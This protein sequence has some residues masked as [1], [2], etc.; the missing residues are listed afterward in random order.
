MMFEYA[1]VDGLIEDGCSN[2]ERMCDYGVDGGQYKEQ[3]ML[4]EA[5][6]RDKYSRCKTFL[7]AGYMRLPK[8]KI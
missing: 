6:Y 3:R 5:Y 8:C 1:D 4:L 7:Y 2:K